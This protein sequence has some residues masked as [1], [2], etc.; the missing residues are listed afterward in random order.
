[1]RHLQDVKR[2]T[3][4]KNSW[5]LT[6]GFDALRI[7]GGEDGCKLLIDSG[8]ARLGMSVASRHRNN[9]ERGSQCGTDPGDKGPAS[10]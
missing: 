2:T 5:I 9:H 10:T 3:K 4:T 6:L 7:D 1:M 8:A